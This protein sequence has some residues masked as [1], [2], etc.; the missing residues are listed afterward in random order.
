MVKIN[1]HWYSS[2]EIK[3]ALEGI[4]YTVVTLE[5]SD[6]PRDYPL[7]ETYAIKDGTEPNCLNTLKSVA[8]K[9]FQR[10]KPKLRS[11]EYYKKEPLLTE[12]SRKQLDEMIKELKFSKFNVYSIDN[13]RK[14]EL[15][16]TII[17]DDIESEKIADAERIRK[18]HQYLEVFLGVNQKF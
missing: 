5:I 12:E 13:P 3:E 18:W 17:I 8:L 2:D 14:F 4:G 7:Y 11:K 1:C 9:E 16:D 6:D 10:E 15:V